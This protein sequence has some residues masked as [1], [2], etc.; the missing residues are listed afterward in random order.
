MRRVPDDAL[1]GD[2]RSD[3]RNGVRFTRL[4]QRSPARGSS[5]PLI[6]PGRPD[7]ERLRFRATSV[8]L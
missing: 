1:R 5:G 4:R 8:R 7:K 2:D 3:R 6:A